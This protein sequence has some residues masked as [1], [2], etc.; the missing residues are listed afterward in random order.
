MKTLKKSIHIPVD[1][2]LTEAINKYNTRRLIPSLNLEKSTLVKKL[3][4]ERQ[5][6]K[7]L[8]QIK[9]DLASYEAILKNNT[10]HKKDT[11]LKELNEV[12]LILKKYLGEIH[13]RRL[14][15]DTLLIP[16][17]LEHGF[18]ERSVQLFAKAYI[19]DPELS[20]ADLIQALRHVWIM[21][22]LQLYTGKKTDLSPE[23]YAFGL[24][25]PYEDNFLD[26]STVS[27][28]EKTAFNEWLTLFLNGEKMYP[29]QL[30]ESKIVDFFNLI[31][32]DF[33]RE[34]KELIFESISLVHQS[35][36]NSLKQ[37]ANDPIT[38]EEA[39]SISFL[40]GGSTVL[41]DAYLIKRG[42][43]F[44]DLQ[45]AFELG[46]YLQLI[47][48]FQDM[49]EDGDAGI[50][51]IFTLENTKEQK[52]DEVKKMLS[53]IFKVNQK[54]ASDT[55][56]QKKMKDFLNY[57]MLV[58]I[59]DAVGQNPQVISKSLYKELESYSNVRLSFYQKLWDEAGKLLGLN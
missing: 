30:V 49:K 2:L 53:Y 27:N 54:V 13:E 8:F 59:M 19:E 21:N 57:S 20:Q 37:V 51:T 40:K 29:T 41:A 31:D 23:V 1:T 10:N 44:E 45:F 4:N 55:L 6:Q 28:D 26:D 42:S 38:E 17:I 9:K 14:L 5:M 43:E 50:Q 34:E 3:W 47:D 35:Q 11:N 56:I 52:D 36:I 7:I 46:T 33:D 58:L 16:F 39:L 15:F 12:A 25:Y 48:D 22:L 18:L 32:S 24:L